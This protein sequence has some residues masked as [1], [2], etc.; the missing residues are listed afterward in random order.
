MKT[1]GSNQKEQYKKMESTIGKNED[2]QS[3]YLVTPLESFEESEFNFKFFLIVFFRYFRR[4]T[5]YYYN[6]IL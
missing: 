1:I 4:K 2:L 6:G 3:P 5:D